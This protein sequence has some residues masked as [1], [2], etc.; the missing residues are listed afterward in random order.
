MKFSII[1]ASKSE[2]DPKLRE[3]LRSISE[4]D[5]PKD[6]V[7]VL[8]IT[9]GTPE[10]AKAIGLKRAKGDI[11]CFMASDCEFTSKNTLQDASDMLGWKP[12]TGAYSPYYCYVKTD[13]ILNKY[14]SLFGCNDPIPLYL[15]KCDRYPM[16]IKE[17]PIMLNFKNKI[18]TLGDNGFFIRRELIIQTDLEHYSHID[19]CEDLRKLGDA[20]YIHTTHPIHHKTGDNLW[21][22]IK[23]RFH[24][25]ETLN[26]QRR[27]KMLSSHVDYL[28]LCIFILL[29]L[30]FVEPLIRSIYGYVKSGIR[31]KAWFL[32][33]IICFITVFL[34]G[35][36]WI[37]IQVR[38]L[39]L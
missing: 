27:W 37:K 25:A 4:Q 18:P 6:D 38:K 39:A 19:N 1:I 9:E 13:T 3:C 12:A 35:A 23:K 33:P 36:L 11:V 31:D 20:L 29:A 5:Y 8:V 30:T 15:G 2:T 28:R 34:Y 16:Y 21:L 24:Y 32:H 14:F 26:Y 10:S 7:E 17:H 22:W